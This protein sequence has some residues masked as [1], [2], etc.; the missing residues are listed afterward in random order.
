MAT[1]VTTTAAAV[2]IGRSATQAT[3][4]ST[5]Q[6]PMSRRY[7]RVRVRAGTCLAGWAVRPLGVDRAV[8]RDVGAGLPVRALPHADD[9]DRG[10]R[11]RHDAEDGEQHDQRRMRR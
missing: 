2:E 1:R 11:R 5:R 4:S 8:G 3:S 6:V 10:V 7:S 9:D